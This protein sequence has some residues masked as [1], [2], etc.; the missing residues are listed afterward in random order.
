MSSAAD[1]AHADAAPSPRPSPFGEYAPTAAALLY[2]LA[3]TPYGMKF[4]LLLFVPVLG[5]W[6]AHM[7]GLARRHPARRPAQ[8]VKLGIIACTALALVLLQGFQARQSRAGAERVVQ[9]VANYRQQHG[10]WPDRLGQ[11]GVDDQAMRRQWKLYYFG[12]NGR[13]TVF[14]ASAFCFFDIWAYDLGK[15]GWSLHPD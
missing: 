4:M 8:A 7:A 9:A 12:G 2:A 1:A 5:V 15:P 14:Y 3:C 6:F 10:A 13:A 11:A